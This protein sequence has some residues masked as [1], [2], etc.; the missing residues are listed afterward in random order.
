MILRLRG[1][2]AKPTYLV[3]DLGTGQT[4]WIS[5]RNMMEQ[6]LAVR[7]PQRSSALLVYRKAKRAK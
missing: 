2:E 6:G 1:L 7:L 4:R 5:G 3:Q